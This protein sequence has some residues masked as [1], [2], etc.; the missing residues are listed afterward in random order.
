MLLQFYLE[1]MHGKNH[2]GSCFGIQ[3]CLVKMCDK[4]IDIYLQDNDMLL[5][6]AAK[7]YYKTKS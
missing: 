1:K 2:N 6:V 3:K 4:G 7:V 5:S